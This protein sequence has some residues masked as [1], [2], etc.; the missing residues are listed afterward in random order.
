MNHNRIQSESD[1]DRQYDELFQNDRQLHHSRNAI[2][3]YQKEFNK[4]DDNFTHRANLFPMKRHII[5]I[6]NISKINYDVIR[7]TPGNLTYSSNLDDLDT[8]KAKY[9]RSGLHKMHDQFINNLNDEFIHD[10]KAQSDI[11]DSDN[12]SGNVPL[13]L[14]EQ[15]ETLYTVQENLLNDYRAIKRQ[16]R[17]WFQLK[18]L[19]LE[20]N[21]NLDLY[22]K[23]KWSPINKK[24]KNKDKKVSYRINKIEMDPKRI[25]R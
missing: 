12:N 5:N 17:K 6:D 13:S 3:N 4:M 14:E 18:E 24:I 15:V 8:L 2:H 23:K 21:I 7:N 22:S 19:M 25:N 20:A 16:Q 11:N 10:I 1:I 9:Y